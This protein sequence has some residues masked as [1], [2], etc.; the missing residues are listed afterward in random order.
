LILIN[1]P[2]VQIA[3]MGA[4]LQGVPEMASSWSLGRRATASLAAAEAASSPSERERLRRIAAELNERA[5]A[6][7]ADELEHE[8]RQVETRHKPAPELAFA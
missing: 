4:T 2:R 6:A 1:A 8:R 7:R 5:V 3:I